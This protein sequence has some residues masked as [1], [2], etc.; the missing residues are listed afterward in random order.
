[1]E[2]RR[3]GDDQR[4][5]SVRSTWVALF[6]AALA[7]ALAL[8][9][10]GGGGGSSATTSAGGASGAS[11]SPSTNSS[12]STAKDGKGGEPSSE[13]AGKGPNGELATAGR[14]A[15]AAE[16]EAA[17]KVV[18]LSFAARETGDWGSQ[19]GTLAAAVLKQLETPTSKLEK[20]RSCLE[21]LEALAKKSPRSARENTMTEPLAA[22]RINGSQAFAFYHGAGGKDYV[23]PMEKEGGEWKVAALAAQEAP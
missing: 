4:P 18:A 17:S 20:R 19:C 14:E 10:C 22:L 11:G 9:A 15:T 5:V 2:G 13:F 21:A 16:R 23:V 12:S 7:C 3:A 8:A 1:M 6:L